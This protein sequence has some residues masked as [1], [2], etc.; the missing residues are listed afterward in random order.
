MKD[1]MDL[2]ILG[3]LEFVGHWR[4]LGDYLKRSVSPWG[5]LGCDVTW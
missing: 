1:V 5:E 3:K 4:S 2:P